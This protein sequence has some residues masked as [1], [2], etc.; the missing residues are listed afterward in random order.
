M[1]ILMITGDR[2]FKPGHA[3]F[4][5]Q[6]R[7]VEELAVVYR[8]RGSMWPKIPQIHFDV[9]TAQDPFWR[10]FLAWFLAHRRGAR[11]NIQVHTDLAGQGSI[12]K[13]SF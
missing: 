4:E 5:L 8:G 11:L 12:I 10:G 9:V 7:A 3:R 6:R 2:S 1:K 13:T